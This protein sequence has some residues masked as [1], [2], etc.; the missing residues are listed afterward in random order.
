LPRDRRYLAGG[1]DLMI[2]AAHGHAGDCWIDISGL[3]ELKTFRETSS[4]VFIGAGLTI[5]DLA[6]MPAVKKWLPALAL[7]APHYASPSL[8]N[9]ATIGGNAANGSPCADGVCALLS[10]KAEIVLGLKGA[11]R[12][13]PLHSFFLAPKRTSLKKDELILGFEVPK[14]RHVSAY[15]KLGPRSYFGISKV[16]VCVS[17]ELSA[18]LVKEAVIACA[19]VAPVPLLARKAAEF[20]YGRRLDEGTISEAAALA[21]SEASPITDTRSE[22]AY[23]KA[24][25]RVLAVRA[26][27]R[28]AA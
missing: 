9:M 8:R 18:G 22:A 24:M 28:L 1:T 27:S 20:L 5:A 17:A 16:T 2:A 14:W 4:S 21:Q 6:E 13:L 26:L 11:K 15:E 7:C 10:E 3:K 25:V 23:R 12:K 19:S